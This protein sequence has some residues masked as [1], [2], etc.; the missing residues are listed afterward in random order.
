[1]EKI[2]VF[3]ISGR[4]KIE[5]KFLCFWYKKTRMAAVPIVAAGKIFLKFRLFLCI[6]EA[7][8]FYFFPF[9]G[10]PWA[11]LATPLDDDDHDP[12]QNSGTKLY[13]I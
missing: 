13:E 3:F 9:Q 12:F 4:A 6:F 1:M 7:I 2:E 8:F 5:E 11:P 10:G